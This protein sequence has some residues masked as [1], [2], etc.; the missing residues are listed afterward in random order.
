MLYIREGPWAGVMFCRGPAAGRSRRMDL[1]ETI[2]CHGLTD[3]GRRRRVNQDQFLVADLS[4][5]LLVR[6]STLPYE[7]STLLT[8]E[9]RTHLLLVAD[10]LGGGPAGDR[11]SSL[12]VRTVVRYVLDV[13]PWFHQL[14]HR[15]D[16][17]E[18]ELTR[19]LQRCQASVEAEVA[20]NPAERGMATTLTMAYVVWPRLYVVHVGDSRCYL[21][22]DGRLARITRDH[23]VGRRL[24]E[25]FGLE[26]GDWLEWGSVMWN[27]I[28]GTSKEL[29]PEVY[30]AR[31]RPGDTLLL[32]TDGLTREVPDDAIAGLLD[33][34]GPARDVCRKLVERANEA[35]GHDNITVV[36][37]RF[38][39]P[40]PAPPQVAEA[41]AAA[42][43]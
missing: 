25:E 16:D 28:G 36:V 29:R 39:S 30:K 5:S 20:E 34:R 1:P 17:L 37:A 35:G 18:A 15:E 24:A 40:E 14:E 26:G 42:G 43:R 13:M 21:F 12:A 23:T 32:C 4:R 2:D 9:R 22:R 8:A 38:R 31:L 19:A 11:A 27:V 33:S 6:Q 41:A 10:G 3:L 7:D